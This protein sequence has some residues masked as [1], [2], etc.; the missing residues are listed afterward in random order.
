MVPPPPQSVFTITKQR[1]LI[2]AGVTGMMSTVY[3]VTIYLPREMV[4][5]RKARGE[6]Q[7]QQQK[8]PV[9]KSMWGNMDQAIKDQR[10]R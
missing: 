3:Y 5:Q 8:M 2:L 1:A 6:T 4:A 9:H 10:E 7:S